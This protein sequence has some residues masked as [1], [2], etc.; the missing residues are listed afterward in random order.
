[1]AFII[2]VPAA[3]LPR[4]PTQ[5]SYQ[6]V[7][8]P[9]KTFVKL[10]DLY[11]RDLW[12]VLYNNGKSYLWCKLHI[13]AVEELLDGA[14]L[15]CYLLS[16]DLERSEYFIRPLER[17]KSLRVDGITWFDAEVLQQLTRISRT[18]E[19]ELH[20]LARDFVPVK[21]IKPDTA[22]VDVLWRPSGKNIAIEWLKS[23]VRQLKLK[24]TI[25]EL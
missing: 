19:E 24:Y 21:M 7:L 18:Q 17:P 4:D 14:S 6:F 25:R 13:I 2:V 12:I 16:G 9:T 3:D 5:L 1:M 10:R 11:S 20:K 15:Q 23:I 8:L 22:I